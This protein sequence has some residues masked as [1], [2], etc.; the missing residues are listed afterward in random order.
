[1]KCF[2]VVLAAV[3]GLFCASAARASERPETLN[4]GPMIT[5]MAWGGVP[6]D[7]ASP[8][9]FAEM[10]EAGFN[11]NYSGTPNVE[12]TQKMLDLGHA[13]GV[14]QLIS[15]PDLERDPEATARRFKDHPAT[16]GY[17]LR[18]EPGASLFPKLGAWAKR[19]QSVDTTHPCYV[20]LFPTYGNAQQW[21]TP[22]YEK[23]VERF[24]AE[25]STPMLSWDHY[26]VIREGKDESGDRLRND[27]YYNLEVCSAAARKANR[28]LWAFA[29]ATA[30]SPYPI[31]TVAHLRV[32]AFSDLAYGAQAIQYFT[33]WTV[34][35][36]VWNFHQGPIEVDGTRTPTFDRVKQVNGEIQ[37]LRG[38]FLGSKVVLVGHA[39]QSIPHGTT[40]YTPA[41]PVKSLET[42][43]TG[44]VVSLLEKG[45][46]RFLVVVNRDIHQSMPLTA[47]FDPAAQVRIAG[48]DG[49][50]EPIDASGATQR[51]L[52]PG[53]VAVFSWT[54]N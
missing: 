36:T 8:D 42:R 7:K 11:L 39:G 47:S 43:G 27:F 24:I 30:H 4:A 10:A 51:E 54:A 3:A 19:I 22:T 18:D 29:L 16:G 17:Y 38:A 20:N 23:Y 28:P 12:I 40:R 2:R 35:S 6:Y 44:G 37:A 33:Y 52:E 1:M 41:A 14:K 21:E 49:A 9:R 45:K 5:I 13:H 15:L 31:P 25:V 53:D 50:L 32:Q 34:K 26:P 46:Q 48:R